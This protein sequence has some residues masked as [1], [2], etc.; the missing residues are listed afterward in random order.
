MKIIVVINVRFLAQQQSKM[1]IHN[2]AKETLYLVQ[3]ATFISNTIYSRSSSN[4]D[5]NI[6]HE[7]PH[8]NVV[9]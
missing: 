7:Q 1:T 8:I 6:L 4:I 2:S 3:Y 5:T 9:I